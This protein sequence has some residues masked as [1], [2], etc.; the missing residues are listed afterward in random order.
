MTSITR[1]FEFARGYTLYNHPPSCS[2]L[3]GHGCVAPVTVC[4]PSLDDKGMVGGFADLKAVVGGFIDANLDH[5]FVVH[6]DYPC[7]ASLVELAPSVVT[8][9]WR[10]QAE[11]IASF[12]L[13][14]L[15]DHTPFNVEAITLGE[16][17]DCS[18][19]IR[20]K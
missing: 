5:R 13:R 19:S 8:L 7:S 14:S 2:N 16:S 6:R 17:S 1:R 18:A 20:R 11:N 9:N 4:A 10:P 15:E 12:L 3:H